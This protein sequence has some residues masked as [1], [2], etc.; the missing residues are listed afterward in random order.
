[1]ALIDQANRINKLLRNAPDAAAF[2]GENILQLEHEEEE[3]ALDA[4][5]VEGAVCGVAESD[6][7]TYLDTIKLAEIL[8]LHPTAYLLYG[9]TYGDIDYS[10]GNITDWAYWVNITP[11]PPPILPPVPTIVYAYL[12]VGWDGDTQIIQWVD[13]FAYG[14]DLITKPLDTDGTYGLLP[15]IDQIQTGISLLTDNKDKI[16]AGIDV[17]SRYIP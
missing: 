2:I 5:A 4:D 1:M 8:L 11:V 13:D 7:T 15:S 10:T 9:P 6:L 14:N 3:L 16:E 12:G 17:F